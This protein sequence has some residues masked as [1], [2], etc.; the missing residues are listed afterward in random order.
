[1]FS[2]RLP[3][4][5]N[6]TGFSRDVVDPDPSPTGSGGKVSNRSA[7]RRSIFQISRET[8]VRYFFIK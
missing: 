7:G 3:T 4:I 8:F 6:A 5:S 1:M 2:I